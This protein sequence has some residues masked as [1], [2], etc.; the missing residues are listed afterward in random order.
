M[1]NYIQ[2]KNP[3]IGS[4]QIHKGINQGLYS[5]LATATSYL[6]GAI[7]GVSSNIF[8]DITN[9]ILFFDVPQGTYTFDGFLGFTNAYIVQLNDLLYY[10][11][12]CFRNNGGNNIIDGLGTNIIFGFECFSNSFGSNYISRAIAG[13]YFFV[14]SSG[15]NTSNYFQVSNFA[16][17]GSSGNNT[18]LQ[19]DANNDAFAS[20]TG[21]NTIG[22]FTGTSNSFSFAFGN[23]HI[24]TLQCGTG[25]FSNSS[26]NNKIGDL[27]AIDNC[28]QLSTGN[29]TIGNGT[30]REFAFLGAVSSLNTITNILDAGNNFGKNY[31]G[32]FVIEANIGATDSADLTG[33]ITFFDSGSGANLIVLASKATSNAGSPEGDLANAVTNGATINYVLI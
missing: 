28:F 2:V 15:K 32:N 19:I 16:F 13:D 30:F 3:N 7:N 14:N 8:L 27:N 6:A 1:P 24:N 17:L 21:N 9:D 4:I 22:T 31:Q 5:N 25:G 10:G 20:S 29:N 26:G 23:N 33:T 11:N 12:K 18:I